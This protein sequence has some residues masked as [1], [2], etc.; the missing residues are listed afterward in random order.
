M[1]I[2]ENLLQTTVV[3]NSQIPLKNIQKG[4]K[5]PYSNAKSYDFS[6]NKGFDDQMF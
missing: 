1:G 5:K 2:S 3:S 4:K 6:H